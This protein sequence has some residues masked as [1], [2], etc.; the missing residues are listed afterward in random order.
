M[1]TPTEPGASLR[2]PEAP[3]AVVLDSAALEVETERV[4]VGPGFRGATGRLT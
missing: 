1:S 4:A 3:V 2:R